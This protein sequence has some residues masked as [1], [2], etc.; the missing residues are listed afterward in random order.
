[1]DLFV[2]G[3]LERLVYRGV[4]I[5]DLDRLKERLQLCWAR[6]SQC[7]VAK[8][9]KAVPR[10]LEAYITSLGGRFEHRLQWSLHVMEA[11]AS[12]GTIILCAVHLKLNEDYVAMKR[13]QYTLF[14]FFEICFTQKP[15]DNYFTA[16]DNTI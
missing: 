16:Y 6:M 4:K 8:A 11:M 15:D 9:I 5:R 1:M 12:L 13:C 10:R 2:W 14:Y 3:G 7:Q